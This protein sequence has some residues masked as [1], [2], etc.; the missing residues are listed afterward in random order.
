MIQTERCQLR[1]L[2]QGIDDEE[3]DDSHEEGFGKHDPAA[4]GLGEHGGCVSAVEDASAL[5]E[6]A[7]DIIQVEE[8]EVSVGGPILVF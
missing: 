5:M 2:K 6:A 4:G 1:T 8:D 7:E 3:E